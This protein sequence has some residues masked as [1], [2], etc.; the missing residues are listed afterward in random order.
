MRILLVFPQYPDSFW[1]F[2]HAI[3]FIAKKATV[4]PLGLITVAAMLPETW[5]K[6]LVDLNIEALQTNDIIWADYVFISAMNIQLE[7]VKEIVIKCLQQN[8]KM[9][10][11]GPLFTQEYSN[12]PQIDHF[13]LNEAEITLPLF[14]SD[15]ENDIFPLKTYKTDEYADITTSPVPEYQLLSK[16]DYAYMN[17]QVSRGC[18]YACDFCEITTLL[19]HKVRMKSPQQVL[20]EIETIYNQD[21][22]GP[23]LIVDDNFIGNKNEIKSN[24]LPAI[25]KWQKEHNFPFTFSTETTINLA[26]DNELLL[27]MIEAGFNSTFI[28]IETPVENSLKD[29]NKLQ[30]INRNL[31][32]S[33]KTIQK[34]GMEVSAGFIVG[35]DSDTSSVFQRQIDFIQQSGIVTAMVGM[36]NAPKNTKLY[37]RLE[38]ENRLLS[39]LSGN[40]TDYSMNFTPV[41]NSNELLEGYKK[42]IHSIYSIKPYYKRIRLFFLNYKQPKAK[43]KKMKLIKM[44]FLIGFL[45]AVYIIGIKNKGRA[46]YWKFLCWTLFMRP[47]LFIE[48]I[49][50]TVYGYHFRTVYGLRGKEY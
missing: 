2:K 43:H 26:D 13:I 44:S 41:M 6:K 14:L 27:L 3:R 29:C 1:S 34:A 47:A 46:E 18:P 22:L 19:G 24:L 36:L 9:I 50:F 42:I 11:G 40:N 32:E 15:I 21:W 37:K 12:F 25:I 28:G 20:K 45:Q 38:S 5:E 17:I 8:T 23:I 39:D 30:N 35:F 49:T 16:K 7:S 10:A 48:A 31:L 33:V 4:P